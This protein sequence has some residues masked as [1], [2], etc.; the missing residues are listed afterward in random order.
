MDFSILNEGSILVLTPETD[1]GQAWVEENLPGDAL[2]WAG[3]Y[4]IEPR[5]MEDILTG[6]LS[7]GLTVEDA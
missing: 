1:E 3:G 2:R 6:I 4:V 5:Y 7:D